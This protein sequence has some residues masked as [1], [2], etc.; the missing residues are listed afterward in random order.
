MPRKNKSRKTG[1]RTKKTTRKR[2]TPKAARRTARRPGRP[3]R[4]TGAVAR[5]AAVRSLETYYQDLLAQR[6]AL[7]SQLGA[8]EGALREMNATVA[9]ATLGRPAGRRSA[10]GGRFRSGSLKEY[11]H[12]V[13]SSGGTMS[14]KDI[15]DGVLRA[16]YPTKNKTLAK[17][18]G[19]ALTEMPGVTKVGRGQFRCG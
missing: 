13:L 3:P 1:A 5:D 2:T 16:G 18:V 11:I 19:I 14:V 15:T 8:V 12:G 17:S 7:D 4:A 9:K 10:G 6:N